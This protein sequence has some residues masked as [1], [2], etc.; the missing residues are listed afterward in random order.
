MRHETEQRGLYFKWMD[1][2]MDGWMDESSFIGNLLLHS[3]ITP[4]AQQ[5]MLDVPARRHS[6]GRSEIGF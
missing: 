6:E 2:W 4:D 1:G 5:F 3:Y